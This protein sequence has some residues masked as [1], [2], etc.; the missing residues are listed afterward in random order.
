M[1]E[2]T[3]FSYRSARSGAITA[4]ISAVVVIESAAVHFAVAARHPLAAWALTLTSVAALVWLVRDY[5]SLGAGAVR[6]EPGQLRLAIGR[7]FDVA[8]PFS[9]IA[10]VIKPSF[11]DLPMPG[12]NEGRDYLNLMKPA[13][14]N[15][16]IGLSQPVRVRLPVGLHREVTRVG[17]KLDDPASFM[18]AVDSHPSGAPALGENGRT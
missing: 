4:A 6:V 1:S 12:T 17:L 10:R 8:I 13:A 18:H 14:P 15:V 16:L 3:R 11:R 2:P 5:R 9:A 7:R